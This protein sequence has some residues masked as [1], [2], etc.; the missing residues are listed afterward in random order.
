V[1]WLT[2]RNLH[3]DRTASAWLIRR[4]LDPQAEFEFFP[5]GTDPGALAG[6]SFDMRGGEYSHMG[7][8]CTFEVLVERHALQSDPALV[9]LGR[10]I[11]EADVPPRRRSRV[12]ADGLNAVLRGFQRST[13][14]DAEKLRL[15]AP[16]YDALYAYCQ[17]KAADQHHPHGTARPALHYQRLVA[18]HLEDDD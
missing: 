17:A 7:E 18:A 8:Q 6:H 13:P 5:S 12:E 3:V 14:D 15:T 1:K 9:E 16:V 11:R 4:F 10:I 2:R